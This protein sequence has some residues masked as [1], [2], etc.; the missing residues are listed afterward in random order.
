MI[1]RA[2]FRRRRTGP[3]PWLAADRDEFFLATKSSE[4]TGDRARAGLERSS[5]GWGIQPLFD[6]AEL[7]RI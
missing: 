3:A 2:P 4:R 1:D 5:S 7:E 6:G